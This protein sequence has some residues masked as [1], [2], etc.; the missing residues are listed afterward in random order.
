MKSQDSQLVSFECDF[1]QHLE[2]SMSM[3]GIVNI[4]V[5]K[6]IHAKKITWFRNREANPH[7]LVV[8]FLIHSE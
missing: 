4:R 5:L 1:L 3:I 6:P 2:V 7:C 8:T